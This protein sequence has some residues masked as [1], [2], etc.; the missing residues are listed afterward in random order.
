MFQFKIKEIFN[1]NEQR[2]FISSFYCY[3]N[4]D[5]INDFVIDLDNVW[6][7]LDFSKKVKAK[8]LL[9]KNFIEDKDYK[10]SKPINTELKQENRGGHNKELIMLNISTFKKYCLKAGTKKA[11]EIHD[12]FIKL[13]EVI[14]D[15]MCE[16]NEEIK[17]IM[18]KK[19]NQLLQKDEEYKILQKEKELTKHTMLLREYATIGSIIYIIKIKSYDNGE[20]VIKI[21]ESRK[22]IEKRYKEHKS[23]YDEAII[24]EC[25][26]VNRSKD[27]ESFLH[28]HEK[29]NKNK[30]KNLLNHEKEIELFLIGNK[31]TYA[32]V[33]NI[34]STN[35]EKFNEYNYDNQTEL[36]KLEIEK[37]KLEND[38]IKLFSN[39]NSNI[40]TNLL[41]KIENIE[42]TNIQIL[43]LLSK[44]KVTTN[45]NEIKQT[46]GD[47]IHQYN[48]ET[49]VKIKT[50]NSIAECIK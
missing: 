30:V 47:I 46:L 4:Y 32:M 35:I 43:E 27:F 15:T 16:E 18:E 19:D 45:F 37:L 11:N 23:N 1:D 14:F 3:L 24:L 34:I 22:G 9:Q 44:Q 26:K 2:L 49:L 7:W 20:Y 41:N 50:Y 6:K 25:F 36:L 29:I 33:L 5:K 17:L 12:Y 8:E 31:L 39:I 21:G 10:I 13:E 40:I 48:P 28:S 38:N 42:N